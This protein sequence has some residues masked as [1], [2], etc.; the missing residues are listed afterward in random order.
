MTRLPDIKKEVRFNAP[1]EKVWE[2]VSTSEG[3]AFWFM[4]NDLKA[5]TGHHFH[6]Q[7]PFGPSPCQ[8]T[9][10]ERPIKLSFTWDTDG[11]SVTFHLKEEENGTIFTIVHSGWKQGDTKVEKAGAE[12]AVVHERMDRGWHDLVNERLRQIV[13]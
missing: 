11:W 3:L 4:E 1:I 7:S 10:V 12:S 6:L 2:A 9:D 13:E 5:E 8:V